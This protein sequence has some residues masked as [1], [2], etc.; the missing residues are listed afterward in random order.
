MVV[1]KAC[2]IIL[3]LLFCSSVA[4]QSDCPAIVNTALETASTSCVNIGRN[5]VCYGNLTLHAEAQ[6]D[7]EDF[8]FEAAGDI[9]SVVDIASLTLDPMSEADSTWGVALMLLQANLPDTV[10]GQNVTVVLFGNIQL[11]NFTFPPPADPESIPM[12]TLDM[13]TQGF[14]FASGVGDAPCAEAP[15][16]GILIQTP[17]GQGRLTLLI[18]EVHISLGST[19]Y[20]QAQPG[21]EMTVNVLEGLDGVTAA[22]TSIAVPAGTRARIPLDAAGVA[23]GPPI[24]PEPYVAAPMLPLQLLP[25]RVTAALPLTEDD[26]SA[27]GAAPP[28]GAWTLTVNVETLGDAALR[29]VP[30]MQSGTRTYAVTYIPPVDLIPEIMLDGDAFYAAYTDPDENHFFIVGIG[31]VFSLTELLTEHSGFLPIG[32]TFTTRDNNIEMDT[33]TTIVSPTLITGTFDAPDFWS[34][35]LQLEASE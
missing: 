19:A 7:A 3:V 5:Q 12:P 15:D 6:P 1:H 22:G 18:N 26:I 33:T 25:E 9:A 30:P 17:E 20:I 4:A 24:G 23:S 35:T 11:S 32:E 21:G 31:W 29:S 16:S 2:L 10:P 8:T 27:L 34:G 28:Q 13:P 14:Y